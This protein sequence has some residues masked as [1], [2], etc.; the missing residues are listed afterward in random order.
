MWGFFYKLT[1]SKSPSSRRGSSSGPC[2]LLE[3][4]VLSINCLTPKSP[5]GDLNE[6]EIERRAIKYTSLS[7][8]FI[9]T[10]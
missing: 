8:L 4:Y 9:R 3:R 6:T 10:P 1:A 2:E 7:A 5:K